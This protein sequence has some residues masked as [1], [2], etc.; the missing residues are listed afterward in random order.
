MGYVAKDV[1][2]SD[3]LARKATHTEDKDYNAGGAQRQAG[4]PKSM[5]DDELN[6]RV[7][8]KKRKPRNRPVERWSKSPDVKKQ[9]EAELER[10]M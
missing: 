6:Q 7:K 8:M 1:R 2:P 4:S 10:P 5:G 3:S 9:E